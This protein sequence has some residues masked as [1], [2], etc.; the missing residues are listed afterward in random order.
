MNFWKREVFYYGKNWLWYWWFYGLLRIFDL[1]K[2]HE[3]RDYI[4]TQLIFD[5][6]IRLGETL[7]IKEKDIDYINRTILLP[8]E[9]TKGKKKGMCFFQKIRLDNGQDLKLSVIN[10]KKNEYFY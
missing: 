7:L 3:Y 4:I 6:G 9:N 8:S 2:F 5:T 1:S 10:N